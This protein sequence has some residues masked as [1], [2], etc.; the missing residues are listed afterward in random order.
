MYFPFCIYVMHFVLVSHLL[1]G[2]F[3]YI[4]NFMHNWHF[5]YFASI[6][7]YAIY[8]NSYVKYVQNPATNI[9]LKR[10]YILLT[11]FYESTISEKR[12][13]FHKH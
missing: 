8:V 13:F 4:V 7:L 9:F 12:D 5:I 2:T 3:I 10:K 1:F 11:L 6:Y